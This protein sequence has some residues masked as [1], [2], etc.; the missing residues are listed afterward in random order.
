M[1]NNGKDTR[2][3]RHVEIRIHFVRNGEKCKIHKIGWCEGG[4]QLADIDT[5]NV[6]EPD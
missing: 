1:A 2:H 3:T 5:R 6:G 4:M